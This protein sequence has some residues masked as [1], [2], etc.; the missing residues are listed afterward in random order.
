MNDEDELDER[1]APCP[2]DHVGSMRAFEVQFGLRVWVTKNQRDRLYSLVE[3]IVKAPYN[4]PKHGVHWLSGEGAR[5]NF[6]AIDAAFLETTPGPQVVPDGEEPLF[7]DDVYQLTTTA[8]GF[9]NER[10]R[11]KVEQERAVFDICSECQEPRYR[12]PAGP[13]CKNGHGG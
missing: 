9:V 3:E 11:R 4:Q 7:D 6:S 5:P 13:V 2:E 8:R 12:T 1:L 10:E